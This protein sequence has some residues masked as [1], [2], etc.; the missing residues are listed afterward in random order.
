[1]TI[2]DDVV[3]AWERAMRNP[4]AELNPFAENV[5]ELIRTTAALECFVAMPYGVRAV[6]AS[7]EDVVRPALTDA[8]FR[9]MRS[10]ETATPGRIPDTM[11]G[12][13]RGASALVAIVCDARY[14][15]STPAA[16][17]T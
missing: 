7:Y 17:P 15:G 5:A 4:N 10:D 3:A 1:M 13:I 16:L 11:L 8:A 12:Q 6:E 14:A 2:P 9:T